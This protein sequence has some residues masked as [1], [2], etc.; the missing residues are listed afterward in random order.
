MICRQAD[1][2]P[3][4]QLVERFGADNIVKAKGW[5]DYTCLHRVRNASKLMD[6][7]L[8]LLA[9]GEDGVNIK[10]LHDFTRM[11]WVKNECTKNMRP[12]ILALLML[13]CANSG[14]KSYFSTY[15]TA[16]PMDGRRDR[17]TDHQKMSR[18]DARTHLKIRN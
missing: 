6:E 15:V 1:V 5:N 3:L 4:K 11:H 16:H 2:K 10:G 7:K 12:G 13:F 18:R 9:L 8:H 17:R 14:R